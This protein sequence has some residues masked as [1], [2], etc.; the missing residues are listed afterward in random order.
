MKNNVFK[1]EEYLA[2]FEFS[3]P[4]LLCCS[5]AETISMH[6]LLSMGDGE[7]KKNWTNLELGY[8]EA[9]GMP[10]LRKIIADVLYDG[11]SHNNILCFA[12]AEEAI[13]CTLTELCSPGDHVVVLSP[14]YQ[15]LKEIPRA[16]GAQVSE[17][18]LKE[19]N[20]WRID[21][22]E[23]KQAIKSNTSGIVV[24][25]PH[26]PTGQVISH[27]ELVA[28]IKLCQQ[29]DLWLLS[30][31]VY[32]LLGTPKEGFVQPAATLYDKAISI[33]VMSKAYGLAGLRIGFIACQDQGL[34]KKIEQVKH[35]TS[36]CCSAP[37]ELL[38]I[39]ALKNSQKILER[40]NHIVAANLALLDQFF[41]EFSD[42]FAWVRPEGGCVGL[43][44]FKGSEPIEAMCQRLVE[45][46]GVLLLPGKVFDMESNHFRLGFGRK[47]MA[48]ALQHFRNF[49]GANERSW[50]MLSQS[51]NVEAC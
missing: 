37:A 39:I 40:N 23:I 1:L 26:N 45:E 2:R 11:L 35:Y 21:I 44:I 31:E 20:Q 15:S 38:S 5:D 19:E 13:F 28:L 47:N 36:I 42:L 3:A 18:F 25:F 8:T 27:S 22:A 16:Q 48:E 41:M 51:S 10:E 34:L 29:H 32:R 4:Y 33:G 46:K 50:R 49:V 7:D 12:G 14:C 30:D 9:P 6:E 24:N 17:V 43:G